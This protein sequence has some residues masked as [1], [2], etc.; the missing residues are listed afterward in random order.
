MVALLVV[1][2][3]VV[4]SSN[5]LGKNIIDIPSNTIR[6]REDCLAVGPS[7]RVHASNRETSVA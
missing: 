4:L 2:T 5:V 3:I 1:C 6:E 7:S